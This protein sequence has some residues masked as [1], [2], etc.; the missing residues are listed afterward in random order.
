MAAVVYILLGA[1]SFQVFN[2]TMWSA[3]DICIVD[4]ISHAHLIVRVGSPGEN[5]DVACDF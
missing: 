1:S 3:L 5:G 2:L 4:E